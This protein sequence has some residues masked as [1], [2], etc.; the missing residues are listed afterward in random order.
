MMILSD[1]SSKMRLGCTLS[2]VGETK[3]DEIETTEADA[4]ADEKVECDRVDC[5]DDDRCGG[6]ED[7]F[8]SI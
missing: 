2:L 4:K 6:A 8:V 3:E 7:T 1:G 5:D